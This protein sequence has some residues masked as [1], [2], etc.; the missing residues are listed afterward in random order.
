M[1]KFLLIQYFLLIVPI[2]FFLI[3][4]Y[5]KWWKKNI[6]S[7]INDLKTTFKKNTYYYKFY[8][9]LIFL[10]FL[11]YT[12]IFAKPVLE[13]S[14]Q[15][16]L[17]NGIDIQIVLDVSYSMTAKDLLPNRL[18]VAKEVISNFVDKIVT[19]RIW[20]IVYSWKVFISMPLNFDYNIVKKTIEKVNID[21]INQYYTFLQWTATGDALILAWK[22]FSND[23]RE[24]VIILLTDWEANKGINPLLAIEYLNKKYSWKIR[25]YTIWIWWDDKTTVEILDMNWVTQIIEIW[26]VNEEML[27]LISSKTNWLYFRATNKESLEY[28]FDKISE[29]EKK[30][31]ITESVK[32]NIEN[33]ITLIYALIFFF[34]IFLFVKIRKWI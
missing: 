14:Y 27:K 25:I 8:Y 20:L 11:I 7:S 2:I 23:S 29:L 30:E 32:V 33:Y 13:K 18:E 24:K 12:I 5:F 34:Y 21:I 6:F 16:I 31:I 9:L 4:L 1:I 28:V 15:N 17:K 19:D 22:L 10:I 26:W 3:L